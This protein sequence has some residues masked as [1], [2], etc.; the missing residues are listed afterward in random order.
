MSDLCSTRR[1][2]PASSV[3]TAVLLSILRQTWKTLRKN[4]S[5]SRWPMPMRPPQTTSKTLIVMSAPVLLLAHLASLARPRCQRSRPRC[6][7]PRRPPIP[8]SILPYKPTPCRSTPCHRRFQHS[9][10]IHFPNATSP[11]PRPTPCP[12]R[13]HLLL[14]AL[15]QPTP[16][17]PRHR[18]PHARCARPLRPQMLWHPT[19]TMGP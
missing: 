1:S 10:S 11:T 14:A 19:V 6:H 9:R 17:A 13:C 5:R 3:P 4:G 2:T 12:S 16:A 18:A 15:L 8:S 7:C